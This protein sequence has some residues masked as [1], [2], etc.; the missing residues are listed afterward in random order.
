[1]AFPT[2]ETRRTLASALD[3]A[4]AQASS[5]KRIAANN[6]DRMAAGSITASGV[7]SL[8]DNLKGARAQFSEAAAL[9]GM[10]AYAEDQLGRGVTQEFADMLA[11]ID[12]AADWIIANMPSSGGYLQTETLNADGSRTERTFPTSQTGGLRTALDALIATID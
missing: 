3:R 1:M 9:P 4:Q 10:G 12:A 2:N 5:I 7:F 6:R 8:L 11:A